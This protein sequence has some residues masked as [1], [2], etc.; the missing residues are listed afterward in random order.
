MKLSEQK[1]Y[2]NEQIMAMS[3]LASDENE[4]QNFDTA[5]KYFKQGL[6]ADLASGNKV[7]LSNKKSRSELIIKEKDHEIATNEKIRQQE[8]AEFRSEKITFIAFIIFFAA[9]S[10]S[11]FYLLRKQKK[12]NKQLEL[13]KQQIEDG[14]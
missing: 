5:L 4:L 6:Q 1:G 13:Q 10:L 14:L 7:F 3:N 9:V 8:T 12:L 11:L 2:R